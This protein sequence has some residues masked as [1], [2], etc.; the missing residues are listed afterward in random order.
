MNAAASLCVRH[1]IFRPFLAIVAAQIA[2]VAA[3]RSASLTRKHLNCAGARNTQ[4]RS[5]SVPR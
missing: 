3:L 4:G 1:G 5:I 2:G